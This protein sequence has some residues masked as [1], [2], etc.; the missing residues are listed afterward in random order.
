MDDLIAQLKALGFD[1]HSE[2]TQHGV[3]TIPAFNIELGPYA[4]R[5]IALAFA[6]ND[7]PKTPPAGLHVQPHLRP[8]NVKNVSQSPIGPDWQYWSRR[9]PDWQLDRSGRHIMSY[10]R[11]VLLDEI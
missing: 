1:S 6:G 7:F 2:H 9:L 5:T 4:G 3:V 10:V 11:K 8:L